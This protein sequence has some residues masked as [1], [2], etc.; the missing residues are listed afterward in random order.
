MLVV[1]KR[2]N[3]LNRFLCSNVR[4]KHSLDPNVFSK[5]NAEH[6]CVSVQQYVKRLFLLLSTGDLCLSLL[7][8]VFQPEFRGAQSSH[9]VLPEFRVNVL[10][11]TILNIYFIQNARQ[12]SRGSR[13]E[14]CWTPLLYK[15]LSL[16]SL[17]LF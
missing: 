13:Q 17:K 2:G 1:H 10:K 3:K 12:C 14:K 8:S 7:N 4:S 15:N 9:E 11:S 5:A 16:F 6:L